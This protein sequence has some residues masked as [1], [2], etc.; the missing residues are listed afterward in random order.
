MARGPTPRGRDRPVVSVTRTRNGAEFRH[1]V[2]AIADNWKANVPTWAE[3]QRETGQRGAPSAEDQLLEA[4]GRFLLVEPILAGLNWCDSNLIPEHAVRDPTWSHPSRMDLLGAEMVY[5]LRANPLL[6]VEV[7]RPNDRL[8]PSGSWRTD[9]GME[10]LLRYVRTL[11]VRLRRLPKRIV[12][13]N[14]LWWLVVCVPEHLLT[15]VAAGGEDARLQELRDSWEGNPES[16]VVVVADLDEMA[17][18][19]ADMFR[20]LDF[21]GLG[22]RPKVYTVEDAALRLDASELTHRSW[23]VR[24]DYADGRVASGDGQPT[25]RPAIVA[26]PVLMVRRRDGAWFRIV[27][28]TH[29]VSDDAD[30]DPSALFRLPK[31]PNARP[32]DLARLADH[33]REVVQ[34]GDRLLASIEGRLPGVAALKQLEIGELAKIEGSAFLPTLVESGSD[35]HPHWVVTGRQRHLVVAPDVANCAGHSASSAHAFWGQAAVAVPKPSVSSP[36]AFHPDGHA[37]H[38][39]QHEV[40]NAK[41]TPPLERLAPGGGIRRSGGMPFCRISALEARMCCRTCALVDVC[42][43]DP[44]LRLPCQSP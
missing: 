31:S 20:L 9:A 5:G 21:F 34:M 4:H 7:K 10:Q 18:E 30:A 11:M 39:A 19:A 42:S 29:G 28:N 13:T 38:C 8:P 12:R 40:T 32:G 37:L 1:R 6:A 27:E 2:E 15:E 26:S 33:S 22:E 41:A 16:V 17:S 43:A 3:R 36:R 35:G 44:H 24:L 23:G 14:G 25:H